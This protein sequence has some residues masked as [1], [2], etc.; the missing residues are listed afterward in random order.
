MKIISKLRTEIIS[1]VQKTDYIIGSD[2]LAHLN[3]IEDLT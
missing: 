1:P 2:L 3:K